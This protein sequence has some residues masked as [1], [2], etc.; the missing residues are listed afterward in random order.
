M[1][2][3]IYLCQIEVDEE[4]HETEF[5]ISAQQIEEFICSIKGCKVT[6]WDLEEN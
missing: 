1:S 3:R 5:S 2:E 4:T 6:G